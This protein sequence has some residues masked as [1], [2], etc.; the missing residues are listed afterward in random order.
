[1][2][3][4]TKLKPRPAVPI[5]TLM[6]AAARFRCTC[7]S[8]SCTHPSPQGRV[9]HVWGGDGAAVDEQA[10][11]RSGR[12]VHGGATGHLIMERMVPYVGKPL[13]RVYWCR[14]T[15]MFCTDGS[16]DGERT[17]ESTP[18]TDSYQ[19]PA[20]DIVTFDQPFPVNKSAS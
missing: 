20:G 2:Q 11:G 7:M 3:P 14:E 17:L 1:M 9:E 5:T 15:I 4:H 6:M 10:E 18:C 16:I 8:T 19:F 13:P 12:H